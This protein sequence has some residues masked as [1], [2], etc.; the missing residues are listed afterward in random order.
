[1]ELVRPNAKVWSNIQFSV[2]LP[3]TMIP[4]WTNPEVTSCYTVNSTNTQN[5]NQ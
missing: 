4:T 1:M 5:T 3:H 2:S